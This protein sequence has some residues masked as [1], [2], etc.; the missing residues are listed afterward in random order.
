MTMDLYFSPM[1]CSLAS[2][3]SLYEAGAKDV[4][5]V[6]VDPKSKRTMAGTNY[7]EI[8]PLGLV[9]YLRLDDGSALSENAAILQY[10]ASHYPNSELAPRNESERAQLQQW[11]CFIGTELHKGIFIPMFDQKA[12]EGTRQ[13]TL[14]K[15]ASRLKYLND[16]LTG[17]QYL[18]DRF[19]VA[20]GSTKLLGDRDLHANRRQ[21][22]ASGAQI[23]FVSQNLS[24]D[25]SRALQAGAEVVCAPEAKPWGQTVGYLNDLNGFIVEICTPSPRA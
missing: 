20:D 2:R 9:P 1:A 21:A 13:H 7:F 3:I 25:W 22:P 16:H 14:N 5:F 10:I 12:P 18:L 11:L 23:A 19:T 17:R 6:E 4:Q 15:Y 24:A 8:Y